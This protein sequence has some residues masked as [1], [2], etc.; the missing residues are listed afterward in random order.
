VALAETLA[1]RLIKGGLS[2]T[3]PA[4]DAQ[5]EETIHA[6]SLSLEALKPYLPSGIRYVIFGHTHRPGPLDNVDLPDRWKVQLGGQEVLV[7]NSGS[8]LYDA[9]KA[10]RPD[11]APQRWPGTFILIPDQGPARLVETLADLSRE[12]LESQLNAQEPE[13]IEQQNEIAPE[14]NGGQTDTLLN[15]Y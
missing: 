6:F 11:Y 4:R 10:R 12:E 8:W 9:G 3:S 14:E 2:L 1:N 7:M 13:E 5:A 15:S